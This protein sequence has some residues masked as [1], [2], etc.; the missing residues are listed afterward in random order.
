MRR[1]EEE[2]K[3]HEKRS[4]PATLIPKW[5]QAER[6]GHAMEGTQ[7][8]AHRQVGVCRELLK[9][10]LQQ[11]PQPLRPLCLITAL[12]LVP[13]AG[14]FP[15]ATHSALPAHP[16]PHIFS[17]VGVAVRILVTHQGETAR[18]PNPLPLEL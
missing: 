15:R 14:S 5:R 3:R 8:S 17:I 1:R 2:K 11:A 7:Q 13:T 18:A 9:D 10:T 16:R 12:R 4:A 6:T